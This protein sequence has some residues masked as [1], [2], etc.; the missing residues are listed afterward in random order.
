[1]CNIEIINYTN[2]H[3]YFLGTYVNFLRVEHVYTSKFTTCTHIQLLNCMH[4]TIHV[5]SVHTHITHITHIM[6]A[7]Y[8]KNKNALRNLSYD[9][10]LGIRNLP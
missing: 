9:N 10:L 3:I 7:T 6:Y 8:D 2:L 4:P 1:M 5:K